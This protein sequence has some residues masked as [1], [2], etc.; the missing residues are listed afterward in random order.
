MS[1]LVGT[2]GQVTISKEIREALGVRPGW[3]AIQRV[4]GNQVVMTFLPPKHRE[5]LKGILANATTVRI[6]TDKALQEAIGQAWGDAMKEKWDQ[7][8]AELEKGE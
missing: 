2:K 4:E 6:P 5:S 7:H 3:R 1:T 8:N